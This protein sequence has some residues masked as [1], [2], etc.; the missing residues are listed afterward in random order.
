MA[1]QYN[2]DSNTRGVNGWGLQFSKNS[3]TTTLG[4]GV[5]AT[6]AVPAS[7]ATGVPT[8]YQKNK[9]VARV[10]VEA[11][12]K[13]YIALNGTAAVPVGGTLAASTSELLPIQ[14]AWFVKTG[15]VIHII[16]AA[17]ADVS[18]AFYAFQS[19]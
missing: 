13:V 6:V 17:A 3:Y 5:E 9:W 10:T 1:T 11:G 12:K 15:D 16:S 8:A 18:I 4:A 7:A 19:V 2:I 14:S